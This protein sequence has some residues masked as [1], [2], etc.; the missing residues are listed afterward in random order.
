[1]TRTVALRVV[2]LIAVLMVVSLG[3][4]FL[5]DLIPGDPVASVLGRNATPE[6]YA[7]VRH[8]L[9]LDQ[10]VV[11]RYRHWIGGVL[12]GDFG[13]TL[14]PPVRPVS[15]AIRAALPVTLEITILALLIGFLVG[16]PL[17]VWAAYR[18]GGAV[19][20]LIGLFSFGLISVPVFVMGFVS[21]L[22]FVFH[23]DAVGQVSLALCLIGA[24]VILGRSVLGKDRR[25]LSAARVASAA[26]L[27]GIGLLVWSTIS[28][29]PRQ[30]WVPLSE[31][32][33]G[34]LKAAFLPSLT[35]ALGLIPLYAQVLRTDM[36]Q[37]LRQDFI[38]V[39]RAKGMPTRHIILRE[40]LRPSLFSL[41]TVAGLSFGQLLGGS[42]IVESLFNLP[43][44]GNLLV[45]SIQAKD[46]PVVQ[47]GVLIIAVVFVAINTLVDI[48]YTILEP[49]VRRA[50]A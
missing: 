12:S 13:Q 35:L 31:D 18:A 42:V 30:G 39:A 22:L 10:S 6:Q 21:I 7:V 19:D 23:T 4:F 15:T 47:A 34:N 41:V 8:Q 9:G 20:R 43:G 27:V 40:A 44:L 28:V 17:G 2:R 24:A 33:A 38:T 11:T 29:F 50:H 46:F 16:I 26:V 14:V 49:R 37:T 25:R 36:E 32:V 45:T 5:L 48:S 3:S 1:M